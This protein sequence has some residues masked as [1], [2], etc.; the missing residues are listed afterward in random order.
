MICS[1]MLTGQTIMLHLSSV[2]LGQAQAV[3]R[4][5][6][7]CQAFAGPSMTRDWTKSS[8]IATMCGEHEAS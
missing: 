3:C 7:S 6:T 5:C 2:P 4:L 8:A 1:G